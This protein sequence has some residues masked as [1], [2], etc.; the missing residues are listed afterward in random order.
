MISIEIKS[1]QVTSKTGLSKRTGQ[2]Y[3][4]REQEA[5][6]FLIGQQDGRQQPFPTRIILTLDDNQIPFSVG[7]YNLDPASI[8]VGQF[9]RLSLGKL[10]LVPVQN[11]SVKAA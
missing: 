4:M 11:K 10:K 5:W 2:N 6:A 7:S 9:Y 3:S 1:D 8:F